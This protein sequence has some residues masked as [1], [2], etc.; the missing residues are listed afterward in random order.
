MLEALK[1][2]GIIVNLSKCIYNVPEINFM[3]LV[4]NKDSIKPDPRHMQ[5]LYNAEVPQN[6][7]EM[8]SFLGTVG[9]LER[10]IADHAT[11]VAPLRQA[12]KA[13][14]WKWG[15]EQ[16]TETKKI[17]NW[18]TKVQNCE[19]SQTSHVHIWKDAW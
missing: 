1:D 5:N 7:T 17:L 14:K 4:F 13:D 16:Q 3:K 11:L 18:I 12:L 2:N 6:Q 8:W 15:N 19:Q 9:S 10:F